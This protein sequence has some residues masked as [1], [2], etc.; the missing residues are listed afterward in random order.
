MA[1]ATTSTSTSTSST[2][3]STTTTLWFSIADYQRLS[4]EAYTGDVQTFYD[5]VNDIGLDVE[6]EC[7]AFFTQEDISEAEVMGR[8]VPY[9]RSDFAFY[10]REFSMS[11]IAL[12]LELPRRPVNSVSEV[13][14]CERGGEVSIDL[15]PMQIREVLGIVYIPTTMGKR[16]ESVVCKVSYNSGYASKP[17]RV[18]R[19]IA[20]LVREWLGFESAG[21]G[22]LIKQYRTGDYSETRMFWDKDDLAV[23]LGTSL[24]LQAE[25]LLRPWLRKLRLG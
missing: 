18:L 6:F 10:P 7:K 11:H 24:S 5:L 21:A 14:L 9:G 3:T 4:G 8:Y 17:S 1:V 22:G 13:L 25:R 23:G 20:L 16:G 19:A 15:T 2:S 12:R